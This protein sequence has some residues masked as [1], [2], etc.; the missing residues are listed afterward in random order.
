MVLGLNGTFEVRFH[1]TV[2]LGIGDS[3]LMLLSDYTL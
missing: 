2:E 1:L 3:F